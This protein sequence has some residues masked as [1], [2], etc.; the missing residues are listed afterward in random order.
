MQGRT[1]EIL[2]VGLVVLL[3]VTTYLLYHVAAVLQ[4]PK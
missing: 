1:V 2:I 3:V 4:V